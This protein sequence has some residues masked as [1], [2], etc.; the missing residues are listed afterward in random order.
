V[1][2]EGHW[3]QIYLKKVEPKRGIFLG[4]GGG[5]GEPSDCKRE[6]VE[7]RLSMVEL[8]VS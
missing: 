7:V 2:Y 5:I 6:T 4:G 3:H 1:I 8:G